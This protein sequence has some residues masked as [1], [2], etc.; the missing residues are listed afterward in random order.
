MFE[1]GSALIYQ[2]AYL[3]YRPNVSL[4]RDQDQFIIWLNQ[5]AFQEENE[6]VFSGDSEA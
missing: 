6:T 2:L 5:D 4:G 3:G 1:Y